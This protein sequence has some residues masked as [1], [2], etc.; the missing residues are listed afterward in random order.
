MSESRHGEAGSERSM[1]MH[2]TGIAQL[3][4]RRLLGWRDNQLYFGGL[5][6]G[7][8]TK[9]EVGYQAGRWRAWATTDAPGAHHGW[10]ESEG[11]ARRKVEMVV[12]R[13][14]QA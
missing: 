12:S 2:G 10:F 5:W 7:E 14:I 3:G 4:V 11:D 8:V 6:V 1:E 13:A 9:S